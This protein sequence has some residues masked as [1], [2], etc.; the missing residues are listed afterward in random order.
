MP[1]K[2]ILVV[3]NDVKFQTNLTDILKRAGYNAHGASSNRGADILARSLGVEVDLIVINMSLPD[4]TGNALI[5]SIATAQTKIAKVIASTSVF[6]DF[7]RGSRDTFAHSLQI[8]KDQAESA[9]NAAKWLA[10][11]RGLLGEHAV[12]KATPSHSIVLLV[13]DDAEVRA[14]TREILRREGYQVLEAAD[15]ENAL[16]LAQR[17]GNIDLL[18]TDVEMPGMDGRVLSRTIRK[19]HPTVPVIY[20]S[21]GPPQAPN[22]ADLSSAGPEFVFIAKPFLPRVLIENV[23]RMILPHNRQS[24]PAN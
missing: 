19:A 7:D 8:T 17:I 10:I 12:V 22:A 23:S 5:E 3:D 15:G 14:F 13:D 21:G 18:I 24:T 9:P 16:A 11:V 4:I 6:S 2:T 1:S 20:I